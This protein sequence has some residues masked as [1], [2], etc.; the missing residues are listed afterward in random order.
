MIKRSCDFMEGSSSVYVAT[1]PG[2]VAIGVWVMEIGN[3]IFLIY[4]VTLCDHLFKGLFD[5]MG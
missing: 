2:L 4:H 5:L 3:K 1:L